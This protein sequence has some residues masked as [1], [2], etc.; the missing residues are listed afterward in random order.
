MTS[1]F[2]NLQGPSLGW[3]NFEFILRRPTGAGVQQLRRRRPLLAR[4]QGG[5]F[6]L[7]FSLGLTQVVQNW[8]TPPEINTGSFHVESSDEQSCRLTRRVR[9][10]NAAEA[11]FDVAVERVVCCR[12]MNFGN[13]SAI[14]RRK[15]PDSWA[16]SSRPPSSALKQKHDHQRRTNPLDVS[17]PGWSRSGRSASS[18]PA[19]KP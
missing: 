19:S 6:G 16:Q 18:Q 7:F 3:V 4:P 8:L 12:P 2:A 1:S 15:Q 10:A 11:S 17:I 13:S 14:K 9:V 5:Q